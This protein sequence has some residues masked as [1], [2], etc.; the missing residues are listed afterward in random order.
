MSSTATTGWTTSEAQPLSPAS[1]DALIRNE[2]PAI[3]IPAFASAEECRAFTDAVVGSPDL[4]AYSVATPTYYLGIVV[5]EYRQGEGRK[6]EFFDTVPSAAK[7]LRDVYAKSFDAA[8]RFR[9]VVGAAW[10]HGTLKVPHE[11]GFGDY[12]EAVSRVATGGVHLHA[13]YAPYNSPDW[14]IGK[15]SVQLAWNLYTQ[16]GTQGG[17]TTVYNAPWTPLPGED[18]AKG[19]PSKEGLDS[20]DTERFTFAPTIGEVVIFNGR[21]PH[22]IAPSSAE[23]GV[24]RVTIGSFLGLTAERDLVMWG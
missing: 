3:R 2:I 9:E 15:I 14:Q 24:N 6:A 4:K 11:P 17:E 8:A 23:E 21:N 22:V 1:L 13:D 16:S 20:A 10:P 5:Y 18:P 7:A 12:C 19:M